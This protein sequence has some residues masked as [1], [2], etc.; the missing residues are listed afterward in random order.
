MESCNY[1]THSKANRTIFNHSLRSCLRYL[2]T[3][4]VAFIYCIFIAYLN[5]VEYIISKGKELPSSENEMENHLWFNMWGSRQFPF[6]TLVN[7]DI[8]Y[9]LDTLKK[10][11]VW[12]TVVQD[13]SRYRYSD[14]KDIYDLYSDSMSNRYYDSK[15]ASGYFLLYSIKVIE[16]INVAKP[17]YNFPRLGWQILDD[18]NYIK[19]FSKGRLDNEPTLDNSINENDLPVTTQLRLLNEVMKNVNPTR[20]TQLVQTTIRNDTKIIKAVKEAAG[21]RCQFPG[22][23]HQIKKRDGTNYIEVAHISPVKNDG[24]SILGN[25]VVLCPNHHKEFDY[26]ER[27]IT[28]QTDIEL[29]G[30]L[31]GNDF[32]INFNYG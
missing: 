29:S 28:K 20:V 23:G 10:R 3:A 1:P 8:I 26:G 5:N 2:E 17:K 31:N 15:A 27:V 16:K 6:T 19:W 24:K 9:W 11:L 25:L 22:C 7:G 12:K 4:S 14:K 30:A 21:F 18:D 13:V 32:T